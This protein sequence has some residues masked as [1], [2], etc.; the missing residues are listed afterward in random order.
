[1]LISLSKLFAGILLLF[2]NLFSAMVQVEPN[3]YLLDLSSSN[4]GSLGRL[5][6]SEP[7]SRSTRAR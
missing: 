1:M 2:A 3:R 5:D 4:K 7:S 6:K